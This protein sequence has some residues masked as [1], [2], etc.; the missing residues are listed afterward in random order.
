[1]RDL[2]GSQHD[3]STRSDVMWCLLGEVEGKC[4]MSVP[5]TENRL[6]PHT[7]GFAS[8]AFQFPRRAAIS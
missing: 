3:E 2:V 4:P 5:W 8:R 6:R 1:M 7:E